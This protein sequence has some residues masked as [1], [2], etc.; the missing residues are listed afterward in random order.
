MPIKEQ[1]MGDDKVNILMVDDHP[2]NLLALEALLS[3]LNQNLVRAESGRDA[4]RLLLQQEFAL[5]LLD[6]EMPW[7]NGFETAELIRLREKSRHTP[8]IFLTAVNKTESHV[9]KGYSVGALDYLTKPFVPEILRT[10]VAAFVELYK[11]SEE[12]KKQA[13]LLKQSNQEIK[14]LYS[15]IEHKNAEIESDRD[16]ISAV[17]D[18]VGSIVIILDKHRRVLRANRAFQRMLGYSR[19]EANGKKLTSFFVQETDLNGEGENFWF[20]KDGTPRLIAWSSTPLAGR[21]GAADYIVVT[22]NDITERKKAEE[23]RLQFIRA[24]AA[25]LEAEAAERRAAFLAEAGSMLATTLDYEETLVNIS[26]LAIPAFADWCF[27]CML[28]DRG[29]V[30]AIRVAHSDP[31][32]E[33]LARKLSLNVNDIEKARLPVARVLRTGQPEVLT[34]ISP[35]YLKEALADTEQF[36]ILSQMGCRSAVLVPIPGRHEVLGIIGFGSGQPGRYHSTQLNLAQELARRVSL[37]LDNARLYRHAQEA[38]RA[39]DEFLAT[40]SHELRTPLNAILGWTQILRKKHVDVAT[41]E[42]AFEAIERN[43]KAQAEL[44]EDMLDVSRIITGRLRL[45]LRPVELFSPIEA[46]LDAVRPAADAKG[47]RLECI[48]PPTG[49]TISGDSHRL[50]QIVWNLLSNA[51]KF[52]PA[53]GTVKVSV[54]RMDSSLRLTVADTGKGINPLFLPHVFDRFRQ[55]ETTISRTHGG[56]GLGLSIARHLV[57]LHGGSIDASSEGEGKGATF[58]VTFPLRE[59]YPIAA[60]FAN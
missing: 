56:L 48:L 47:V 3:D 16:F 2:E 43:A 49:G 31:E 38:N 55:A 41:F 29:E 19:E 27:V 52:T 42:R 17:L 10:K 40:L 33:Q 60:S 9:Y 59:I 8:I 39:K 22:G 4:L 44:I 51:V 15:E 32:L 24:E 57:E 5:I 45:E 46:A 30:G 36:E 13:A 37:A 23:D 21:R 58:T 18:T 54:E 14:T 28:K 6:V 53:G 25:R 1:S 35:D 50:Q 34:D 11:K 7:L 26:R 12:V 20:A